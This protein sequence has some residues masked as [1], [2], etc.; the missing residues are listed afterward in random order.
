M[1]LLSDKT[2]L[3]IAHD[4]CTF[5]KDHVEAVAPY[6]RRVVVLP[7]TKPI[8]E[9]ANFL[10]IGPLKLHRRN[11]VIDLR[12]LP[13][14]VTV[15]PT[16]LFYLP[17]ERGYKRL[18]EKHF[19]AVLR[20][21]RQYAIPFDL[22]HAQFL[23][24]AGYAGARLK[25]E[26][27]KPFVVTGHGYDVYDLPYRDE[28]WRIL[29]ME[30]LN[31]ADH[32]ITVSRSNFDHLKKLGAPAPVTVIPNGYRS[33]VFYPTAKEDAR[34]RLGLPLDRTILLSV[35]FLD[36]VKGHRFLV[37]A[38]VGL[39]RRHPNLLCIILGSGTQERALSKQI[40]SLGLGEWVRLEPAKPHREV[41]VWMNAAD[42][43]VHPS[44]QESFGIVQIEAM[45]CG[46][47]VVATRNGGSEE[48]VTSPELGVLVMPGEAAEIARG[49]EQAL[50]TRY[51]GEAIRRAAGVYAWESLAGRV[52]EVYRSVLGGDGGHGVC[53]S[54]LRETRL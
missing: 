30:V 32:V 3:V 17:T 33:G 37:E 25:R 18:G 36:D 31:C 9:L 52:L 23:W 35:G 5:T 39:S 51:D 1:D 43:L 8:A 28:E 6:F 20:Q 26:L 41:A 24:T 2:L 47:P 42:L 11:V 15:L 49:V 53:E 29:C 10:P 13:A 40:A 45:A 44:L 21:I 7:R 19:R 54:D 14:N 50:A 4:Y 22:I 38:M 48:I 12:E 16:N 27:S 46:K 34:K